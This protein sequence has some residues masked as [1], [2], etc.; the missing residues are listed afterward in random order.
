MYGAHCIVRRRVSLTQAQGDPRRS[1][2]RLY[3]LVARRVHVSDAGF[4]VIGR[5][6]VRRLP[7]CRTLLSPRLPPLSR[8]RHRLLP[9]PL[10]LSLPRCQFP[11]RLDVE[12]SRR[13]GPKRSIQL[14]RPDEPMMRRDPRHT[15]AAG[16]QKCT[17][18]GKAAPRPTRIL[19]PRQGLSLRHPLPLDLFAPCLPGP[20]AIRGPRVGDERPASTP[21][22]APGG[23]VQP[24]TQSGGTADELRF[25]STRLLD[26]RARDPY[27][28]D[29]ALALGRW[30]PSTVDSWAGL[31]RGLSVTAT[32]YPEFTRAQVLAQHIRLLAAQG[33]KSVTIRGL[34]SAVRLCEKITL[35]PPTVSPIH[36]AMSAGA[37]RI[38][39]HPAPS[40]V[41]GTPAMLAHMAAHVDTDLAFVTLGLAVLSVCHLLRVGEVAS[42]RKSDLC[43]ERRLSFYHSKGANRWITAPMGAWGEAWRKRLVSSPAIAGRPDFLPVA[44]GTAILQSTMRAQLWGTGAHEAGWHSWRRMGA[45]LLA[46]A[47][48]AF[49]V[50]AVWGR[51]LTERQAR[52]YSSPPLAWNVKF[53][54]DLP[55]P[56]GTRRVEL[57]PTAAFQLWPENLLALVQGTLAECP[58]V[59]MDGDDSDDAPRPPVPRPR[60]RLLGT[61]RPVRRVCTPSDSRPPQ[62]A[63]RHASVGVSGSQD[64]TSST[65]PR[66][67]QT[68]VQTS[69]AA[70]AR[71]GPSVATQHFAGTRARAALRSRSPSGAHPSGDLRSVRRRLASTS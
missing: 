24:G 18:A 71:T 30:A 67:R 56:C 27:A 36:W 21:R 29:Q 11:L 51:W 4:M 70:Q 6:T 40:P 52:Y 8:L 1:L 17:G 16:A 32:K 61:T 12:G 38:Y 10:C 53:P 35:I 54:I 37:D 60:S 42:I 49:T 50:I 45:A 31:L 44:A 64:R 9:A 13:L 68:P 39:E 25:L 34:L 57:R 62:S 19:L 66:T 3:R 28:S 65:V 14:I 2:G 33:R 46:W 15:H 41:W 5:G 23:V 58:P 26:A 69:S 63:R 59:A 48:A 22:T 20:M 43:T 47:G 7:R 55:W